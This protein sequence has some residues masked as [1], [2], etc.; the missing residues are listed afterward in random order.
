MTG[1]ET[2]LSQISGDAQREAEEQLSAARARADE[3]LAAAKEEAAEKSQE[4]IK[5]GEKKAQDIRD[6]AG[7]AAQLERRNA[8]LLFKQQVIREAVDG[9]RAAMEAAPDREYF[10]VL[11]RLA[12]QYAPK[13]TSEMRLN[14]RDLGRLPK[15][16]EAE[17]KKAAPQADITISQ[18]PADLESGFLLVHGGID[19]NCAFRAIFEGAEGELRDAAG[20]LLFPGP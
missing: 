15:D 18:T 1:L 8:T 11:L 6:R 20:K 10:D 19:V 12:A 17:L 9:T 4:I 14:A 3:I 13:G 7:S 5:D 16:F 2:I